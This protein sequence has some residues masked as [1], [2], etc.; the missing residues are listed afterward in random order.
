MND[1]LKIEQLDSGRLLQ[2]AQSGRLPSHVSAR[3]VDHVR[4]TRRLQ[5]A[6]CVRGSD[7]ALAMNNQVLIARKFIQILRPIDQFDVFLST[8]VSPLFHVNRLHLQLR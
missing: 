5:D 8:P 2:P 3:H 6:H 7:S 4:E 1:K